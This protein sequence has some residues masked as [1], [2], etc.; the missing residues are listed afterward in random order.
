VHRAQVGPWNMALGLPL[1][2]VEV[3]V[4]LVALFSVVSSFLAQVR[5]ETDLVEREAQT[6][7]SMSASAELGLHCLPAT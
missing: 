5:C 7:Q 2:L 1:H 3:V 4:A 6:D